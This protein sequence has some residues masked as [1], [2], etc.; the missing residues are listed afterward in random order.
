MHRKQ[1]SENITE[2]ADKEKAANKIGIIVTGSALKQISLS[3][4]PSLKESFLKATDKVDVLLGCRI[5]P[6]QKAEIV[7]MI[8]ERYPN[9]ITLAIGDGA[10]DVNMILNSHVGVGIRGKEGQQAARSADYAIGQFKFLKPLMFI[11]GREAYR[12]NSMLVLYSFYKNVLY[13]SVQYIFSL[14]SCYSG[15]PLYESMIYQLYNLTFTGLPILYYCLFDFEY[16]KDFES[17]LKLQK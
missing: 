15:Q 5:S 1:E 7:N 2:G 12:R 6:A 10:N 8:K 17:D 11:H 9:K 3:D 4:D 13:I 14:V 16:I